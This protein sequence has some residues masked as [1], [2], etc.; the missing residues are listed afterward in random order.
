MHNIDYDYV[1]MVMRD[2]EAAMRKAQLSGQAFESRARRRLV[3]P[4]SRRSELPGAGSPRIAR[5]S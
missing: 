3:W 4:W 2:R 5:A 1:R